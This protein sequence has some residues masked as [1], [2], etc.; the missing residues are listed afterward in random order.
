MKFWTAHIRAGRRPELVREGWSWGAFFFGALWLLMQ[1]AWIAAVLDLA[2]WVVI[3]VL[4]DDGTR[5]V[6]SVGLAIGQG[7]LGR[8]LV[9]WS[10][11][12]RGYTLAHVIAARDDEAALGRL[13]QGRPDL[14]HS[15]VPVGELR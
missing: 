12:R 7:L 11:A 14:A 8:D 9:R 15:F 10:L 1:R 13:L 4:T 6:L 2:L 3:D 5:L